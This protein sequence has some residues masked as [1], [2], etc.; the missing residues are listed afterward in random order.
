MV[1]GLALAAGIGI[2]SLTDSFAG[3]D[4]LTSILPTDACDCKTCGDA[5]SCGKGKTCGDTDCGC[6]KKMA[7]SCTGDCSGKTSCNATK[8]GDCAMKAAETKTVGCACGKHLS[9]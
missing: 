8:E 3:T 5:C 9:S 7:Q 2:F 4:L 1:F 6:S